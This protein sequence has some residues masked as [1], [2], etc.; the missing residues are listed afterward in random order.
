MI[1]M[2]CL[3]MVDV[4][5]TDSVHTNQP[6]NMLWNESNKATNSYLYDWNK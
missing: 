5:T 4:H 2:V 1:Q 3:D 6:W